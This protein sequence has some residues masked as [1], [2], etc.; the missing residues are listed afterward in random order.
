[1]TEIINSTSGLYVGGSH[2]SG[3]DIP[4]KVIEDGRQIFVEGDEYRLCPEVY[5]GNKIYSFK[6]KTNFEILENIHKESCSFTQGKI[7]S[8]AFILC[9]KVI[10]DNKKRDITGTCKEICDLLQGIHGCRQSNGKVAGAENEKGGI[11]IDP[12]EAQ[13][14][15]S[16]HTDTFQK[17]K[18]GKI[19]SVEDLGVALAVDHEK[20]K[21]QSEQGYGCLMLG[22]SCPSWS[23]LLEGVRKEDIYNEKGFGL[24]REPHITLLY[25]FLE[26]KISVKE[27]INTAKKVI[28]GQVEILARG[29]S[30]FEGE[31]Y[32]VVKLDVEN[33]LLHAC[34]AELR[35]FPYKETFPD[36][37][38]HM[39]L[40]YVKKGEGKKYIKTFEKPLVFSGIEII[41]SHP[42]DSGWSGVGNKK[43]VEKLMKGG[44]V[45]ALFYNG[46]VVPKYVNPKLIISA[47]ANEID[48][49]KL[50]EYTEIMRAEMLSH[51]FPPIE[52]FPAIIDDSDIGEE[53]LSGAE[54]TTN[55]IGKKVW[56]VT[57]G[58]HR[59]LSAIAANLPQID[60]VLDS[61]T[62]T[63]EKELAAYRKY[64]S[65]GEVKNKEF[66]KGDK[67]EWQSPMVTSVMIQGY[68]EK[69]NGDGAHTVIHKMGGFN[70][71]PYVVKEV[72]RGWNNLAKGGCVAEKPKVDISAWEKEQ[73]HI[74]QYIRWIP[75]MELYKFREFDRKT[76]SPQ[77]DHYYEELKKEIEKNGIIT[78]LSMYYGVED[79]RLSVG[80]GNHRIGIALDLGIES[81]PVYVKV[82]RTNSK[83]IEVNPKRRIH[84]ETMYTPQGKVKVGKEFWISMDDLDYGDAKHHN[85]SEV[86][87]ILESGGYV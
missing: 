50:D 76:Y 40:G 26:D 82:A 80:E 25:G 29:A 66:V 61:S 15:A 74:K 57:D 52:G 34:N 37:K 7:P 38:P 63:D 46:M 47:F 39:T 70:D 69:D 10:K 59:A 35:K 75:I 54:V 44:Q 51:S 84:Y 20:D 30:I 1:M 86:M 77:G 55:D 33:P 22:I 14:E 83:G 24:E 8:G 56:K 65:G 42:E 31:N 23:S 21:K 12:K 18:D 2:Q 62:I 53:F 11:V 36:Y 17:I 73:S 41:Y 19:V 45:G 13:K 60:V 5:Y 87:K 78:P 64:K 49:D 48:H 4:E 71:Y 27:V 79:K 72:L 58:H 9:K 43:E 16:I 28:P 3:N 32:D 81:L 6:N 68:Y 85:H 67:V